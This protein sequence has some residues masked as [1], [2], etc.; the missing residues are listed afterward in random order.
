MSGKCLVDLM[1]QKLGL[2]VSKCPS[3]IKAV[4]SEAKLIFGIAYGVNFKVD[5]WTRKVNFLIMQLDDFNV[6]LGDEFFLWHQRQPCCHSLVGNGWA[7]RQEQMGSSRR[8]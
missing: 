6:I 5:K 7:R 4:D 2:K 3:I 1:V 8:Y